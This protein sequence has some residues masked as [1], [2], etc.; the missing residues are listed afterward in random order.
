MDLDQLSQKLK[1][2][3]Y[4]YLII[5]NR[6]QRKFGEEAFESKI[7][8]LIAHPSFAL[9]HHIQQDVFVFKLS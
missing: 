1:E 7:N 8:Q 6:E 3:N 5:G 2:A 4:Q 9:Q